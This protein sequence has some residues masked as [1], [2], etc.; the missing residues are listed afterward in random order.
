MAPGKTMYSQQSI[1]TAIVDI[2]KPTVNDVNNI[3]IL[4]CYRKI[5][6]RV[7]LHESIL[8]E[9]LDIYTYENYVYKSHGRASKLIKEEFPRPTNISDKLM[10]KTINKI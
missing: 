1:P 6:H 7:D 2:W 5:K 4:R 3:D 8:K 10:E 9:I